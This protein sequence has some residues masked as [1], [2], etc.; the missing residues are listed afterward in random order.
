[1]F[2]T[3]KAVVKNQLDKRIK[4]LRSDRGG[5]YES[6]DLVEFCSNHGIIYQTATPYTPQQ[7]GVVELKKQTLID[8][9]NSMLNSSGAP[10]NLWGEALLVA[11]TIL[12]RIPRKKIISLLMKTGN[13]G[14]QY[15][16]H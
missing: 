16:K 8:M 3:F 13:E 5:E 2:K 14:Y 4:V 15:I 12:N 7:N 10:H 11:N 1:M 6:N 9:I